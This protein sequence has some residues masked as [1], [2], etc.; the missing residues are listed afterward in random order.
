MKRKNLKI[1]V[2]AIAVM[3]AIQSPM[4]VLGA[5]T[6][7]VLQEELL[8]GTADAGAEEEFLTGTADETERAGEMVVSD[9]QKQDGITIY[10]PA[11]EGLNKAENYLQTAVTNP[12][13]DS[14][15]GEWAVIAMAI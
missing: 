3:L 12:I 11:F 6:Y 8:S 7:E 4:S 5:E 15:G 1:I 2:S 9:A 13:V 14:I 10:Q